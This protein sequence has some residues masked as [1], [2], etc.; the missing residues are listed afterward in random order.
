M[1]YDLLAVFMECL[2]MNQNEPNETG[3]EW[4]LDVG[5]RVF[6]FAAIPLHGW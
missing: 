4:N 6:A 3:H 5:T 1:S 2:E